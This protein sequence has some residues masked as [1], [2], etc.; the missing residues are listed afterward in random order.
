VHNCSASS[1]RLGNNLVQSGVTRPAE[2]AAHHIVA[3]GAAR[4]DASR[5]IL[6]SFDIDID[7]AANGVFLPR[8]LLSAN[9]NGAAVHS[10]I[11]THDYYDTVEGLLRGATNRDEALGVLDF[12]RTSLLAGGFP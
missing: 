7:D 11:H 9:P 2:S 1:V 12:V 5:K 4:A 10:K 3:G 8:N 6:Q